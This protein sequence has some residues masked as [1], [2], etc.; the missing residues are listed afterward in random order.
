MR[1]MRVATALVILAV[2]VGF[3]VSQTF[4]QSSSSSSNV[5]PDV[6]KI[7]NDKCV[8]CHGGGNPSAGLNLSTNSDVDAL[9]GKPAAEKQSIPFIDPGHPGDSYLYMKIEGSGGIIGGRMPLQ[10]GYLSQNQID[11]VGNWINGL[12]ASSASRSRASSSS[13]TAGV[14]ETVQATANAMFDAPYIFQLR[15]S[16][17]HGTSG[18][19]VSLFGPPLAGDAF[20]K[21]SNDRSIGDVIQMGRK[22]QDMH[23]PA[24]SG[25]PRF[26]SITGGKLQ[27]LIDYLKG[28]L[29]AG[30]TAS[31]Q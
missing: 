13:Q 30:H 6:R 11:A 24:Y 1:T 3:V 23:Y 2:A 15:C 7:F 31:S 26:Q 21:V 28:P 12:T 29:Q 8:K 17:C 19:G 18:E 16:G 9:L 22:Y 14:S 4:G 25:M 5:P 20:V 10:G 27:A